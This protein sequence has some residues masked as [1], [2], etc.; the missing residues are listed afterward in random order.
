M[1]VQQVGDAQVQVTLEAALEVERRDVDD[2]GLPQDGRVDEVRLDQHTKRRILLPLPWL[3]AGQLVE[4]VVDRVLHL[5]QRGVGVRLQLLDEVDAGE[6]VVQH[7]AHAG[8]D[9]RNV[10]VQEVVA[11]RIAQQLDQLL[12]REQDGIEVQ[13][14]GDLEIGLSVVD[15]DGRTALREGIGHEPDG[16]VAVDLQRLAERR[17]EGRRQLDDRRAD[18]IAAGGAAGVGELEQRRKLRVRQLGQRLGSGQAEP[19]PELHV[20]RA[21]DGRLDHAEPGVAG[22]RSRDRRVAVRFRRRAV[23]GRQVGL[24]LRDGHGRQA[25]A[26]EQGERV[27]HPLR[28]AEPECLGARADRLEQRRVGRDRQVE[29][30][31]DLSAGGSVADQQRPTDAIE[32][33]RH[34]A[35]QPAVEEGLAEIGEVLRELGCA[36]CGIRQSVIGPDQELAQRSAD[37]DGDRHVAG[38]DAAQKPDGRRV[39]AV[40]ARQGDRPLAIHRIERSGHGSRRRE[41]ERVLTG[42]RDGEAH[43]RAV[44]LRAVVVQHQAAVAAQL[45]GVEAQPHAIAEPFG[46]VVERVERRAHGLDPVL[47]REV[48]ALAGGRALDGEL[49]NGAVGHGNHEILAIAPGHLAGGHLVVHDHGRAARAMDD[50]VGAHR[51][52]PQQLVRQACGR[53]ERQRVAVA[54]EARG[55]GTR[56]ERAV[57]RGLEV[58]DERR[59]AGQRTAR[60][61][62]DHTH[63]PLEHTVGRE[64][65][66]ERT[67]DLQGLGHVEPD[68]RHGVRRQAEDRSV[69][70]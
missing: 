58:G 62:D 18:R 61:V 60:G 6:N 13:L 53:N 31:T 32:A 34:V 44:A 16:R 7:L 20:E 28:R 27:L 64:L 67:L 5:A 68:Q 15:G 30:R 19:E 50:V 8:L 23:S 35:E 29:E 11:G 3:V 59:L 66:D 36:R 52:E 41:A 69:Q 42:G 25:D 45:V 17:V 40:A 70:R 63:G 21:G 2:D 56:S 48:A 51:I 10:L 22:E 54:R 38:Q 49:Q 14:R 1:V 24:E 55:H 46:S 57:E 43:H 65:Q 12:D 47:E 37:I 9:A 4:R 39:E 33:E 26:R